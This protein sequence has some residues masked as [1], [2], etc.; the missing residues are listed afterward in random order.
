MRR[1]ALLRDITTVDGSAEV[2]LPAVLL[3]VDRVHCREHDGST[4]CWSILLLTKLS[5]GNAIVDVALTEDTAPSGRPAILDSTSTQ[6]LREVR[7]VSEQ[8]DLQNDR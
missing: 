4:D 7:R 5:G 8:N 6:L 1:L 2:S 3:S